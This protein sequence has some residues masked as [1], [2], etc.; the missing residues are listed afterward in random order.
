MEAHCVHKLHNVYITWE[1]Q[2]VPRWLKI[3]YSTVYISVREEGNI[4]NLM[5]LFITF[6]GVEIETSMT[7]KKLFTKNPSP[8][9]KL[10]KVNG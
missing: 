4:M 5:C 1:I 6:S 8:P 2:I 3:I 7:D 10:N 9:P